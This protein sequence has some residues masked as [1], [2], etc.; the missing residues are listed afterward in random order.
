MASHYASLKEELKACAQNI[1]FF[2]TTA[3]RPHPLSPVSARKDLPFFEASDLA[4]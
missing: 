4:S 3:G 2:S 1:C